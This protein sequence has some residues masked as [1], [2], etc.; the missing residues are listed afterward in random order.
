MLLPGSGLR[1]ENRQ[2]ETLSISDWY[3]VDEDT[4]AGEAV[5]TE[6]EG[7]KW[8]FLP[9]RY[10]KAQEH[11]YFPSA[12]GG[13]CRLQHPCTPN[14]AIPGKGGRRWE[15]WTRESKCCHLHARESLKTPKKIPAFGFVTS[16]GCGEAASQ[17]QPCF[18]VGAATPKTTSPMLLL[19]SATTLLQFATLPGQ[20]SRRASPDHGREGKEGSA[21]EAQEPEP[22]LLH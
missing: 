7:F 13:P 8:W 11:F 16:T 17:P 6:L 19:C 21:R 18:S 14:L 2:E 1:R 22:E 3:D 15:C 20:K 12:V 9:L 4:A 10:C 5:S